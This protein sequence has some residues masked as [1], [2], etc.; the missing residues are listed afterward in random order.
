MRLHVPIR[1]RWSD[2]DAYG[3]VNNAEM[4]RLLEEARIEAFWVSEDTVGDAHAAG[5]STAVLDGRPG[6]DTL[7]LIA[8]QEIEYLVPIPYL[9]QPLDI[10]LW[11]GRLGGA[12]LEVCYEVCSTPGDGPAT[13]FTKAATTIVLVDA[14]T[15]RPRRINEMERAAWEPYLDA[16]VAFS[17]RREA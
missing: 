5:A 6:A 17:K 16:P 1:L 14:V 2:L 13:V 9:R 3:H 11:L 4:L 8:R 10:Q 12:S 7:T 15:Q